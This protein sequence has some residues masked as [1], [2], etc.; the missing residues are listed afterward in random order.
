[1]M[2]RNSKALPRKIYDT[3]RLRVY[4]DIQKLT[5][6][7]NRHVVRDAPGNSGTGKT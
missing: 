1:M 5:M 2:D 7:G 4:G 6:T 3:P